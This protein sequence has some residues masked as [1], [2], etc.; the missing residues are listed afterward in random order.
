MSIP[1]YIAA[2]QSSDQIRYVDSN[3]NIQ[4][5]TWSSSDAVWAANI[6]SSGSAT[7]FGAAKGL[8]SDSQGNCYV[9]NSGI[10][11]CVW[12]ISP[13]F[14]VTRVAGN[15]TQGASGDGGLAINAELSDPQWVACDAAG[16]LYISDTDLVGKYPNTSGAVR[17]VNMQ[18]TT[19]VLCGVSVAPGYIETVANYLSSVP[20]E[21][22]FG[23]VVDSSGNL[24][25]T[26]DFQIVKV[27]PGGGFSSV[28][29]TTNGY[30]GDG[31]VA[32]SA[33]IYDPSSVSCDPTGNLYIS[34]DGDS[35]IRAVSPL[36]G[37]VLD[38]SIG[39]G[40]INTVVGTGTAGFTSDGIAATS[41][42][43]NF[44]YQTA[45][46]ASGNLYICDYNNHRIRFVNTSTGIISTIAG[47]GSN[48]DTGNGGPATSAKIHST[49]GI[50]LIQIVNPPITLCTGSIPPVGNPYV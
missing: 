25:I 33:K 12:K 19:Q 10:G 46:D 31:S 6:V 40:D 28:A 45:C 37:V 49:Y 29:G 16:N 1:F 8:C 4:L 13:T 11:Y 47:T 38:V 42:E 24:Y 5:P 21:N 23:I 18:A 17:V 15:G 22:P 39:A 50:A 30:S 34:T 41:S 32:T 27:T 26:I 20:V 43:I 48:G 2:G 7:G 44:P 14:V 9:G 3:G 35:R 36:G